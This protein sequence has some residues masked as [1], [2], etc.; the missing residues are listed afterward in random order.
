MNRKL[1]IKNG[2]I[3]REN[4]L[5]VLGDGGGSKLSSFWTASAGD[6]AWREGGGGFLGVGGESLVVISNL[7]HT[8]PLY[9]FQFKMA[10]LKVVKARITV[11]IVKIIF[12]SAVFDSVSGS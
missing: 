7:W 3:T 8:C 2:Y 12:Y 10:G 4:E 11:P 9:V 6:G 1:M 5:K